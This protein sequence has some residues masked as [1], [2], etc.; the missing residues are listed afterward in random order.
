MHYIGI[1]VYLS[2]LPAGDLPHVMVVGN[3]VQFM[4]LSKD[5]PLPQ[6]L[7]GSKRDI[8]TKKD[9]TPALFLGDKGKMLDP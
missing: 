7:Q 8:G 4:S 9:G 5:Y 2:L 6:C 1:V 3:H